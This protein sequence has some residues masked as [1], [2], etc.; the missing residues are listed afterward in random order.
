MTPELARALADLREQFL[1]DST[2]RLARMGRSLSRLQAEPRD[3]EALGSLRRDFHALAGT[4][5][6]YGYPEVTRVARD[7]DAEGAALLRGGAGPSADD[8]ARFRRAAGAIAGE[9]G[10]PPVPPA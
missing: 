7:A 10:K 2:E 5:T 6:A 4:G 3:A 1:A 8:V 9:L